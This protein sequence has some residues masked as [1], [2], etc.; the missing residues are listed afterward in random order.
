K[1][2]RGAHEGPPEAESVPTRPLIARHRGRLVRAASAERGRGEPAAAPPPS[3][4]PD[5][6][7]ELARLLAERIVG[8]TLA[9]SD[10]ALRSWASTVI[11]EARGARSVHLIAA[12]E[13]AERLHELA[14]ELT[15]EDREVSV[16][17]NPELARGAFRVETELGALEASIERALDVLVGALGARLG[18]KGTG[19]G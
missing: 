7:V 1:G 3:P 6:V 14:R 10:E 17:A 2:R 11:Q 4:D 9:V 16:S 18:R 19:A 12:P 13:D 5:A 15:D 8:H